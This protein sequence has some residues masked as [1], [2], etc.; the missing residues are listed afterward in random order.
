MFQIGSVGSPE[1]KEGLG[2]VIE[3]VALRYEGE[4]QGVRSS[5]YE[6]ERDGEISEACWDGMLGVI[7]VQYAPIFLLKHGVERGRGI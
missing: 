4:V 2:S 1:V 5:L 7:Q 3:L 6:F